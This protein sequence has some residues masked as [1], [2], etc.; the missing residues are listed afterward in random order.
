M[1]E[2]KNTLNIDNKR[3]LKRLSKKQIQISSLYRNLIKL[4]EVKMNIKEIR[5]RE[6]MKKDYR[7]YLDIQRTVIYFMKIQQRA[8]DIEDRRI[9]Q[10]RKILQRYNLMKRITYRLLNFNVNHHL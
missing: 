4:M 3:Q 9:R 2:E 5:E 1:I 7:Q 8:R 6:I 10:K